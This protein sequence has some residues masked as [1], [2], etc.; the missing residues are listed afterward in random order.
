MRKLLV[1]VLAGALVVATSLAV[2]AANGHGR[3]PVKC[4]DS[5]WHTTAESTSSTHFTTVP[6]F[7]D[8]PAADLTRWLTNRKSS[9]PKRN[10][11][12]A[13]G[14]A[15]ATSTPRQGPSTEDAPAAGRG[16]T[17]IAPPAHRDGTADTPE[18]VTAEVR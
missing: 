18:P 8:V 1:V 10:K 17:R 3:T 5:L 11:P 4:M 12:K 15:G 6:G 13:A 9:H 16:A 2:M 14:P 7:T